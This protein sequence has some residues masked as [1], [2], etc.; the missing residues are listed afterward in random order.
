MKQIK[1]AVCSCGGEVEKV[2]QT[3]EECGLAF[4]CKRCSVRFVME[5][6]SP[7]PKKF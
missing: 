7:E 2:E 4:Q 3:K 1:K 6:E 5:L